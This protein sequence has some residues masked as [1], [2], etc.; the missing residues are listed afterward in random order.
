VLISRSAT[1]ALKA[2]AVLGALP[3][4]DRAGAALI[5]RQINAPSNYLGKLLR[6]LARAGIVEGRKGSDG[7]FRLARGTGAIT[8]FDVLDPIEHLSLA[9][10]C[11]LGNSRCGGRAPCPLHERWSLVRSHYLDFL[12]TT[13]LA[14]MALERVSGGRR[15]GGKNDRAAK[16]AAGGVR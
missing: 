1:H 6:V 13:T 16:A 15:R 8:L 14:D 2:L 5:A 9:R 4:G 12:Q 7:G 10:A 11:I 3:D